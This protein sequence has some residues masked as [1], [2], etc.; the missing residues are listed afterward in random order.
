MAEKQRKIG[1]YVMNKRYQVPVV[2][3]VILAGF[4][5]SI[6][7]AIL[8]YKFVKG[9]Y[10]ILFNSYPDASQDFIDL[11]N[12]DLS[13]FGWSL[14]V[15]STLITIV[16]AACSLVISHRTAG[17]GYRIQ[18]TMVEFISGKTDSRIHLRKNDDFQDLAQS[19]NHLMDQ[20]DKKG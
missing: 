9:N 2:L 5:T 15:V 16:L 1:N 14:I 6:T 11:M 8:F 13:N 4:L 17:A 20:I 3:I 19:I 7:N 12:S 18:A 10:E